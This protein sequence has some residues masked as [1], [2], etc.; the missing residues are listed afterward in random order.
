MSAIS[1]PIERDKIEIPSV[2]SPYAGKRLTAGDHF[3]IS[4]YWFATNFVLGPLLLIMLQSE[5]ERMAPYHKATALGM[6]TGLTALVALFV[7]LVFGALSDRCA[8]KW[9]RRRP[10]MAAG[11]AINLVGFAFMGVA[12]LA[13][14]SI[15]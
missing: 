7:P 4:A 2:E 5:M 6:V 8:S 12:I 13:S 15:G 10:Y 11:I 1:D 3:K 14:K 9:G